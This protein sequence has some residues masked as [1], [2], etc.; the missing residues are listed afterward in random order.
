MQ[1]AEALV[2][3]SKLRGAAR[4][5]LRAAAGHSV[6]FD[7]WRSLVVDQGLDNEQAVGLM[8]GLIVG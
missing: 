5:R 3:G 2:A 7:T 1:A 8:A 4:K 6:S